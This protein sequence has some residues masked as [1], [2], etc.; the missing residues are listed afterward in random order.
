MPK[1]TG[2]RPT[3]IMK[4][5]TLGSAAMSASHCFAGAVLTTSTWPTQCPQGNR[6]PGGKQ[7]K[8]R[9]TG[10]A[11]GPQTE[12]SKNPREDE[13]DGKDREKEIEKEKEI[14]RKKRSN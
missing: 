7:K 8:E 5:E 6:L 1:A 14:V 4:T 9:K 10:F 3:G 13:K 11:L 2:L 12:H